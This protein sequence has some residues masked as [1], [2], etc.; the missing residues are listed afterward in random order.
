MANTNGGSIFVGASGSAKTPAKGVDRPDEVSELIRN[1]VDKTVIPPIDVEVMVHTSEGKKVL[2]VKVPKGSDTPY[3]LGSSQIFVRQESETTLAMRDE[4]IR[5][6]Q[7]GLG[8]RPPTERPVE[9]RAPQAPVAEPLPPVRQHTA[10]PAP[11]APAIAPV[12]VAPV[13]AAPVEVAPL[14]VVTLT[15][16]APRTGVEVIDSQ[17]VDNVWHHTVQ[18]LRNGNIV[19]NVTNFSA[20]HLWRYAITEREEHHIEDDQVTWQGDL[21][22]WKTYRRAGVKRYNLVQ[23]DSQG[24]L[25]VYYGVTEDGMHGPWS[26]FVQETE[27]EAQSA[28]GQPVDDQAALADSAEPVAENEEPVAENE[29]PVAENEEPVAENEEPVAENEEPAAEANV[30][31]AD[32]KAPEIESS[33]VS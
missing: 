28:E 33:D 7:Q 1:E 16:P 10:A 14:P 11:V 23:R 6:V 21:G 13:E 3:V 2:E 25:H 12:E 17:E 8:V 27:P 26:E 22:L 9:R 15:A 24:G 32:S 20:R 29:E 19:H 5:L 31:L 18:D 4:V 30:F